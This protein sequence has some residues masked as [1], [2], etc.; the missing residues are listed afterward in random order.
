MPSFC[1]RPSHF[2]PDSLKAYINNLTPPTQSSQVEDF[3]LIVMSNALY[4]IS[5]LNQKKVNV[6]FDNEFLKSLERQEET[7]LLDNFIVLHKEITKFLVDY[8]AC[9]E[10]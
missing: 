10:K 2:L 3:N 8:A 6:S 9:L 4:Q 7:D 5:L 1:V